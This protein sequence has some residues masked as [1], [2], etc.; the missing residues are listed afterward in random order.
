[1][2]T[3]W[4]VNRIGINLH[5]RLISDPR[6]LSDLLHRLAQIG[7]D[8][9]EPSPRA[10][11]V[12][13][14]ADGDLDIK[15]LRRISKVLARY[16]LTYTVHAPSALIN[17]TD[18]DD[19]RSKNALRSTIDFCEIVNAEILVLHTGRAKDPNSDCV[20]HQI[21]RVLSD[22]VYYASRRGIRIG[23]ENGWNS[24]E[25]LIH[26]DDLAGLVARFNSPHLG[27]TLDLGHAF[28]AANRLGFDLLAAVNRILP[29]VI[30]LHLGDHYG[31]LDED[32]P[33]FG[34]LGL[35]PGR[36]VLPYR[37]ILNLNRIAG[38]YQGI[39]LLDI[40]PE[41]FSVLEL[42]SAYQNLME[43]LLHQKRVNVVLARYLER[44][45]TRPVRRGR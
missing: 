35:P 21:I 19:E 2:A 42:R 39:Y 33:R 24:D 8:V 41:W 20:K 34:D 40:K 25:P 30:H 9:V 18:P 31:I 36:G 43:M 17:I 38:R 45:L 23:L 7:F 5:D 3:A 16:D 15:A 12:I 32:D 4:P 27:I 44:W 26:L 29:W 1:M 14:D 22:F 11:G 13:R 6:Q 37:Q 28:L 10:L